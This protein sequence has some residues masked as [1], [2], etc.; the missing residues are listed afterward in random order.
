MKYCNSTLIN[1]TV[2]TAR[3]AKGSYKA[4]SAKFIIFRPGQILMGSDDGYNKTEGEGDDD[5]VW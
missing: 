3:I 5:G 2:S 1:S 4:P